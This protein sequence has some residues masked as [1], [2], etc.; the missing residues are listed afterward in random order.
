LQG[1]CLLLVLLLCAAAVGLI[2][3][4]VMQQLCS[5]CTYHHKHRGMLLTSCW[6]LATPPEPGFA[7]C[8]LA[9]RKL[10]LLLVAQ[11]SSPL[12]TIPSDLLS[13]LYARVID[14]VL[15]ATAQG[16]VT[17]VRG[18]FAVLVSKI[19]FQHNT[20]TWFS[21]EGAQYVLC[22]R[23]TACHCHLS[24]PPGPQT[25]APGAQVALCLFALFNCSARY[26][27]RC[28]VFLPLLLAWTTNC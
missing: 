19:N 5:V 23:V 3:G 25:P 27:C 7:P 8:S 4:K 20:T 16:T 6:A 9:L 24:V 10:M 15:A 18:C 26:L 12:A 13:K 22:L 2:S 21:T 14:A 28:D 17:R 1:T 11:A